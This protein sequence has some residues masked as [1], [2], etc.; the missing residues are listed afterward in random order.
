[1]NVLKNDF[2]SAIL[3]I[4]ESVLASYIYG[5][6]DQKS[7][8]ACFN[9]VDASTLTHIQNKI[10]EE[11]E[12]GQLHDY[13]TQNPLLPN[14]RYPFIS[15]EDKSNFINKFYEIHPDLKYV[16]SK[17]AHECL[18]EY[19]DKINEF[20]SKTLSADGKFLAMRIDNAQ[21]HITNQI[22]NSE[23][24]ILSAIKD[25]SSSLEGQN[26]LMSNPPF[27]KV[28]TKNKLFSGRIQE[29]NAIKLR[30]NEDKLVFLTGKSGMGKSQI[31]HEIIFQSLDQYKLVMW[32]QANTEAELLN[33]LNTAAIFYHLIKEK[34]DDFQYVASLLS[35]FIAKFPSALIIYDSADDIPIEFLIN[36]C[37]FDKADIL[38]TTQNSNIDLDE[39]SV[40]PIGAFTSAESEVFLSTHSSCRKLADADTAAVSALCSLLENYPL[41]LEYARAYVNK[42]HSSFAEYMQIYHE[43]K[44]EILKTPISKY[45]K[46]AYTAWKISYDK[47][48][49]QSKA[50]K[51]L[52]CTI[53]LLA[54]YDIPLH[55]IFLLTKQYSS[56]DLNQ[57]ISIIKSYSLITIHDEFA[58]IHGITQEFIRKQMLDDQEYQEY[59]AKSLTLLS[60]LMPERITCVSDRDLVN[61][62]AKHA[63]QFVSYKNEECSV[64]IYRFTTNV[65][66]KLYVL[67]YYAQTIEFISQ[68]LELNSH[69]ASNCNLL[70]MITFLTQAYHYTGKDEQALTTLQNYLPIVETSKE[71]TDREKLHLLSRYK[72]VEGIILK[73][74][75]KFQPSLEAFQA[76]LEYTDRLPST[77]D[78]EMKCNILNNIGI[79]YKHLGQYKNALDYYKRALTYANNEKHLLL[80][81][82]GNMASIYRMLN[83]YESSL[84]YSEYCLNYSLELGDKR[85]ECI[86][87]GNLGDCYISMQQY[88][89]AEPFLIKSMKL[90]EEMNFSIGIINSCHSLGIIA[91][92][93][94]NYANAKAYWKEALRRSIE[95]G[96]K[97]GLDSSSHALELLDSIR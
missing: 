93:L 33:E 49:K 34:V 41:A 81:V 61:R 36:N 65:A 95:T 60:G 66:S 2:T 55:D 30:L 35:S 97:K 87:L 72:N 5:H 96:Y 38:I 88:N 51:N 79:L 9:H 78:D 17:K 90:A 82:Y 58:D 73:D 32:F 53:S 46:T 25:S 43:H 47:I 18:G 54:S 23:N 57:I 13:I 50:A 1:M 69:F 3:A 84:K 52:L 22:Q 45:Q 28:G 4:I 59:Y 64:E 16:A 7:R 89:T 67:G 94:H 15:D 19:V 70:Q 74:Q 42:T 75:G 91:F 12:S 27:Y 11:Y 48:I 44:H 83:Q 76:S 86:C 56:Y 26:N 77:P 8:A 62:L 29:I 40:I 68:Q 39:F 6:Q 80:R 21:S 85:N 24:K 63:I 37:I 10:K 31:A 20:L 92:S 14:S 71:L